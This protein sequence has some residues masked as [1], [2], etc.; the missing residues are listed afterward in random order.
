MNVNEIVQNYFYLVIFGLGIGFIL[1]L[2]FFLFDYGVSLLSKF[3][4]I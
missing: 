2:V 3:K 4:D 1:H